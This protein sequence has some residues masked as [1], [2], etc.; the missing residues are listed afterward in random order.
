[1][2]RVTGYQILDV[3]AEFVFFFLAFILFHIVILPVTN[4]LV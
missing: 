1:M 3:V 2:Q 4:F